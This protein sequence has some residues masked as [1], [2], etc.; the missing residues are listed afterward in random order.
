MEL[1]KGEEL[2]TIKTIRKVRNYSLEV[3]DA[4]SLA[5][6]ELLGAFAGYMLFERQGPKFLKPIQLTFKEGMVTKN[7]VHQAWCEVTVKEL[8]HD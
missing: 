6:A 5:R 8:T 4:G 1:N 7:G 2:L 3:P